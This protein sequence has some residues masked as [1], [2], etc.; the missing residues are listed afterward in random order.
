MD[1][2]EIAKLLLRHGAKPAVYA[3]FS[4]ETPD[5]PARVTPLHLAASAGDAEMI[6]LLLNASAAG[7]NSALAV[8]VRLAYGYTPLFY[9]VMSGKY[10]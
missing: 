6:G 9:A 5:Q 1:S 7:K 8:D 4:D 2:P 10:K 3:H